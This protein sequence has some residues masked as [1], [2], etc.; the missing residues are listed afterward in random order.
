MVEVFLTHS[1]K[2]GEKTNLNQTDTSQQGRVIIFRAA[3]GMMPGSGKSGVGEGGPRGSQE[4]GS[5]VGVW[6]QRGDRSRGEA[7]PV[8]RLNST[9]A[10]R[11]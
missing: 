9:R 5:F 11:S 2:E 1:R 6:N 4:G 3:R 8:L 7:L 10:E